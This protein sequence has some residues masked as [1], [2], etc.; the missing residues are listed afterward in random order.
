VQTD[1]NNLT[2]FFTAKKL[3]IKQTRWA[4]LLV[5]YNFEIKY[6]PRV[7]NLSDTLFQRLDFFEDGEREEDIGLLLTL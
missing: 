2:Y 5:A 7:K 4:Q 6:K 1:Y 3:N